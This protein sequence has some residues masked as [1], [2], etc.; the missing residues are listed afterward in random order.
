VPISVVIAAHNEEEVLGRSLDALLGDAGPNELELVVVCNGCVDRTAAVARG[1]GDRV[2]VIETPRASK[3]GALNLGDAVV[4][5]FPRLYVDADVT[6]S[7]DSLRRIA[8]SLA[9]GRALAAAP[10]MDLDLDGASFG[11]RAYYRIWTLL[12]YVREGMIGVGVYALSRDGRGRFGAFPEVL[13]DDGYVRMLFDVSERVRVDD[14]PVRVYAPK[15]LSDLTRIKTRSVLGRYQL[16]QRFPELVSADRSSK[17]YGNALGMV[18]LRP[19]LWPAA[20][21]YAAVVL[22]TRRRAR[23]RLP[24]IADYVWERDRSS[25]ERRH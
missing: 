17:S 12:P 21:V 24:S 22:V 16:R 18:A 9:D 7:F 8:A 14:A 11:V 19:W 13:A 10:V 23:R 20:T 6:L 3:T 5:A 4:S 1:Y 15:R 2:R 25:R